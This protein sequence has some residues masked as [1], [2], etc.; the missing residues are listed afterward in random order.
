MGYLHPLT[1]D[2]WIAET[3]LP[4]D[5]LVPAMVLILI[6]SSPG[7]WAPA[8]NEPP[9][10]CFTVDPISSTVLV[11]FTVDA[12]CSS[13]DKTPLNK[14]KFRWNWDAAAGTTLRSR[15]IRSPRTAMRPKD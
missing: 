6:L 14:L 5:H 4:R 9:R 7:V 8:P 1:G 11:L 12:S 10:A 2:W 13:D 15:P 3:F